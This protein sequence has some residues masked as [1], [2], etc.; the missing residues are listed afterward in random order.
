MTEK[1]ADQLRSENQELRERI[2]EL[3]AKLERKPKRD[4]PTK[5]ESNGTVDTGELYQTILARLLKEPAIIKLQTRKPELQVTETR[6]IIDLSDTTL[7]GR[8]AKLIAKGFF[9]EP[10]N[11]NTAFNEL[12]RLGFPTAKPNVYRECDALTAMG[13]LTKEA[14]GYQA[15]SDMKV[16]LKR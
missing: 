16:N 10:K 2:S 1:E 12:K 14:S 3:E 7:R 11:G 13:F 9:D 4:E 8:L 15:V 6:E 5:T